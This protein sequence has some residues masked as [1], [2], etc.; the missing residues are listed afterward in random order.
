M[1]QGVGKIIP[2]ILFFFPESNIACFAP[3]T[4]MCFK[5]KK[6]QPSKLEYLIDFIK[7]FMNGTAFHLA[8]RNAI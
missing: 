7:R 5:K 8:D 6:I 3:S 2:N 1:G 4:C